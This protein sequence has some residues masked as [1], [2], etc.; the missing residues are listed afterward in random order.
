MA[1]P[2]LSSPSSATAWAT[3]LSLLGSLGSGPVGASG[4]PSWAKIATSPSAAAAVRPRKAK[5]VV[6]ILSGKP[7]PA[8]LER[9][10]EERLS[11]GLERTSSSIGLYRR[12]ASDWIGFLDYRFDHPSKVNDRGFTSITTVPASAVDTVGTPRRESVSK[13]TGAGC[14]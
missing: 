4:K 6:L 2:R 13:V 10:S 8:T 3:A 12:S 5:T 9:R 11:G 7:L 1:A 14:P